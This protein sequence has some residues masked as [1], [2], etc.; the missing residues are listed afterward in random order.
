MTLLLVA[1][2]L[3]IPLSLILLSVYG[4]RVM[5][6]PARYASEQ[7][8]ATFGLAAP[9]TIALKARDGLGLIAWWFAADASPGPVRPSIIVCH[10]HG[11]DKRASLW[12]AA[13]L[14]PRYNVLLLDLRGHGESDWA[15]TSVGYIERLDIEG[16]VDW[17]LNQLG[18]HAIGVLGISMGAGAAIQAAA[19]CPAIS[20]VVADS[21]FARLTSPVG[22]VICARGYPRIVSNV[23]AWWV[24]A[25]A[26]WLG[27]PRGR[28]RDPIDVVARIAPRPLLLIHGEADTLIPVHNAHALYR[29]AGEPTELWTVPGA[30]HARVA[31]LDHR[32]YRERVGAFFDLWL[33]ASSGSA[34]EP[35]TP[36]GAGHGQYVGDRQLQVVDRSEAS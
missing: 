9:A 26:G 24:C 17:L 14:L 2:A 8:A 29:A 13:D 32:A 11:A 12:V 3:L 6:R 35:A 36:T 28:W 4:A 10:G 15:T 25:I 21:P 7:S 1:I 19:E 30:G 20:A 23:L 18:P 34:G 22:E 16:G 33:G 27:Q 5:V 31:D